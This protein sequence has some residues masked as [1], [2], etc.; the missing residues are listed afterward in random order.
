VATEAAIATLDRLWSLLEPLG[1]PLA[2]MGGI[3]LAAWGRIRATRDVDLLVAVDESALDRVIVA[4]GAHGFRPKRLPPV[5]T[6]GHHKFAQFLYTP[7]EEF[8]DV[9]FDL[10]LAETALQKSAIA[11]RIRSEVPGLTRSID[12]LNCDDLILF[13]LI[14]GRFI[15]RADAAM[16]LR[17]NRDAIDFDY[18]QRWIEELKVRELYDEVWRDA[19]PDE[20][21]P[22]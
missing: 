4:L 21:E 13:K 9:Q 18:L 2:V 12:V 16:L 5:I 1:Y 19:F 22:A 17:D 20:S 15:D 6:V 14:A 8:Y 3:S 7:P 10:L 11:R